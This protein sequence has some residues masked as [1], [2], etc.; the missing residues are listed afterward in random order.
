MKAYL[1]SLTFKLILLT[2]ILILFVCMIYI[3]L[4]QIHIRETTEEQM[5]EEALSIAKAIASMEE[6]VA[7]FE[8]AQPSIRIQPIAENLRADIGAA[9]IVVGNTEGIRYSHPLVEQIGQKMVGGDNDAALLDQKSYVSKTMGG[10]GESIRGKVPIMK[11][12]EVIGVV[13]VG[14][15]T[16][17]IDRKISGYSKKWLIYTCLVLVIGII[18]AI[19]ISYYIKRLLHNMEPQ[20]IAKLYNQHKLILAT[21]EEGIIA[22]DRQNQIMTINNSA[23]QLVD[24][25]QKKPIAQWHGESIEHVFTSRVVQQDII[26]NL[27]LLLGEHLV[28]LNKAPLANKVGS[29]YTFRRKT[30]IQNVINELKEVRQYAN[31][32]RA[33]T[34]EF[35]NKLHIILGLLLHKSYDEAIEFIREERQNQM[36]NQSFLNSQMASPLLRALIQGKMIEAAELGIQLELRNTDVAI[37]FTEKQEGAIL[38]ALGNVLQNAID[39]LKNSREEK[40]LIQL[41]IMHY[42]THYTFEI[43]D[44]GSGIADAV[45]EQIF[46][47]GISTKEGFDRGHGLAISK[48]ALKEVG[49]EITVDE[50]DLSGACFIITIPVEGE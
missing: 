27:E 33:Q 29:L 46:M 36:D 14:F 11:E 38:T 34:H 24:T 23:Y 9:F 3:Y 20:Q 25:T 42:K 5:G 10:L 48:Q 4:L 22:T 21:T 47:R 43:Q 16:D 28:I 19:A 13:S 1:Q 49:G 12:G 31:A 15:L 32:Q 18:G 37:Q 40:K 39:I 30:N 35:A 7:A 50:G 41:S 8:D 44:S 45:Y 2:S 17:F 6:I 26:H